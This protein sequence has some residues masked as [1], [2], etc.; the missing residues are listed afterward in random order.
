LEQTLHVAKNKPLIVPGWDR[1]IV[2]PRAFGHDLRGDE[3]VN[4]K[5]LGFGAGIAGGATGYNQVGDI[6]TTTADGRPLNQIWAEYQAALALYNSMRDPLVAAL[7]FDVTQVIEDVFQAGSQV[8]FEEASEFG[9]PRS[10]RA[11]VPTYFSL[12][13]GFKWYDIGLRFTWQFLAENPADQVDALN[14]QVLEADN[15]NVFTL[16]MKQIFN[17]T[18][19]V[20]TINGQN[21]NVYPLYNNDATVPPAYKL[22]QPASPHQHYLTSGAA[23]VD[24]GDLTGTGSMYAHLEHHG[25]SWQE[26][27]ALILMVNSAQIATIRGF[28]VGV[29]GAEYDYIQSGAIP[30][31]ALTQADINNLLDRPGASPPATVFGLPVDG[32]YGPWLVV[33]DDLIPAG[34]M[35]GFASGGRLSPGNLV[36]LRGHAN[37]ALRG[38]RLVK[39]Q[40]PD[41]PLIDSYYQRG[42]GT[43]IRQRG[44]A[45]VM[46]ITAGAYAIPAAY[47]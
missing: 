15:R 44:A 38:L 40:E 6:V 24:P 7:S 31:W 29:A 16:M 43:G 46:Q 37:A 5:Y 17:N 3:F 30:A 25:Y 19:R 20:A 9:V 26:G 42:I 32:R 21:Y 2:D 28:R 35:L 45:V 23:T 4:L 11:P 10:I 36:G 12:G 1:E 39:G 47:A 34:Y 33:V 13:Y 18:T 8:N 41:Y 22:T 14:N 27:S